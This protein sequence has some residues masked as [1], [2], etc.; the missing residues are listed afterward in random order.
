MVAGEVGAGA[1]KPSGSALELT[2]QQP[3]V[4]VDIGIGSA[5]F[6]FGS[7]WPLRLVQ[8]PLANLELLPVETRALKLA[9][10]P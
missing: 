7:A 3:D 1:P 6:L 4:G 2:S 5:H 9:D 8:S 10:V